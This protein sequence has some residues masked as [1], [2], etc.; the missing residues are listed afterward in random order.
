MRELKSGHLELLAKGHLGLPQKLRCE[1]KNRSLRETRVRCPGQR[2]MGSQ[3]GS[4]LLVI[5][6]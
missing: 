1:V 2:E 5:H 4:D 6:F 3:K